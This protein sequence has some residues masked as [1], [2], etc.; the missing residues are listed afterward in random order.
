MIWEKTDWMILFVMTASF[1]AAMLGGAAGWANRTTNRTILGCVVSSL[2]CGILGLLGCGSV[3]LRS[4]ESFL[5]SLLAG[6]STGWMMGRFGMKKLPEMVGLLTRVLSVI[7][8]EL[9]K[10]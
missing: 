6:L 3:L 7:R 10:K 5:A 2:N 4:P 9:T 8:D 1:V